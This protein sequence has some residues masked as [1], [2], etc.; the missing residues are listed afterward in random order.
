MQSKNNIFVDNESKVLIIKMQKARD[1]KICNFAIFNSE[2]K[3][4]KMSSITPV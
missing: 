4:I 3:I 2:I 1:E